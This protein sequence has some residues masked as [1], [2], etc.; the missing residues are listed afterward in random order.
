VLGRERLCVVCR[1]GAARERENDEDRE[2]RGK[3]DSP[4]GCDHGRLSLARRIPV[5]LRSRAS[6]NRGQFGAFRAVPLT[7]DPELRIREWLTR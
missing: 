5:R 4:N 1:R 2:L 7:A 3:P 6:G